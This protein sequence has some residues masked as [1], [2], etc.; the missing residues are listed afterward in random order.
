MLIKKQKNRSAF[1]GNMKP[2]TIGFSSYTKRV[3]VGV[4]SN[5]H[6]TMV[7]KDYVT[8]F[9]QSLVIPLILS[10]DMCL[11]HV[12]SLCDKIDGLFLVGGEDINPLNYGEKLLV[13]YKEHLG[14]TGSYFQRP[15]FFK[16]DQPRDMFELTL[17][18][19]AKQKGL[20]IFGNCRGMQIINIAEGGSL[21]QELP[22]PS[23]DHLIGA[24][25]WT[26]Y[27]EVFFNPKSVWSNILQKTSYT[28][29]SCH[30]QAIKEIAPS[31][32]IA[33]QSSDGV[34]EMIEHKDAHRFI[35]GMQGHIEKLITNFIH[36][37]RVI[38]LFVEAALK[39]HKMRYED[40]TT[41]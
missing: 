24:D 40:V 39:A 15:M 2:I 34:I 33:G 41:I 35:L 22:Q 14:L 12:E 25:G 13:E 3:N 28:T 4:S 20:P 9:P 30:H 29:S 31:L 16:P 8:L 17:Y 23:L 18:R 32:S 38:E 5:Q 36:Y 26:Y 21:F 27:H 6:I 11:D 19:C 10:Q 1:R 37:Q 7:P